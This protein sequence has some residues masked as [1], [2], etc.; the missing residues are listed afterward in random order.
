MG[1]HAMSYDV[2]IGGEDFNYTFNVSKLFYDHIPANRNRGGLHELHG[3]TGKQ[4]ALIIADA[5][6][7]MDRTYIADWSADVDGEPKFCARYD[8]ANGWG[9][10]VGAMLFLANIMGACLRHPRRKVGIWA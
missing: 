6:A 2:T 4:A 9:S 3:L 5:F 1:F 10:T 8:S 7:A